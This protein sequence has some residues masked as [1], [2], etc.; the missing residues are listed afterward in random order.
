MRECLKCQGD[1]QIHLCHQCKE[2]HENDHKT[3]DNNILRWREKLNKIQTLQSNHCSNASG[4]HNF[5]F[6]E[7]HRQMVIFIRGITGNQEYLSTIRLKK[8]KLIITKFFFTEIKADI[9][10]KECQTNMPYFQSHW[11]QKA[12]K[13]KSCLDILS[14]DAFCKHR[15]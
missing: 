4:K 12:L 1:I 7:A 11:L 5:P 13:L 15:C 6:H 10:L 9:K 8:R 2:N 3:I 14:F